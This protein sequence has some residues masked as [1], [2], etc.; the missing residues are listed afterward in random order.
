M[1]RLYF[2]L[3][4]IV[5]LH[6]PLALASGEEAHKAGIFDLQ[7]GL[8][9]WTIVTFVSL[10]V[11]L[12]HFAWKPMLTALDNREK[13]IRESLEHADK[14]QTESQKLLNEAQQ[15]LIDASK[16]AKSILDNVQSKALHLREEMTRETEKECARLRSEAETQIFQAKK[17]AIAELWEELA[18]VGTEIAGKI[19]EKRL[20]SQDDMAIIAQSLKEIQHKFPN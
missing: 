6:S 1:N 20:S 12:K 16:E 3:M 11:T 18:S 19:L 4:G 5:F 13:H 14:A 2:V 15:K 9:F 7:W 8:A 17:K 10:L